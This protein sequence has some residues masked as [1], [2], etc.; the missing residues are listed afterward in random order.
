MFTAFEDTGATIGAMQFGGVVANVN[1]SVDLGFRTNVLEAPF[2]RPAVSP[3]TDE[4][5]IRLLDATRD[6]PIEAAGHDRYVV[7]VAFAS[8]TMKVEI[9][10]KCE[11]LS[12][13]PGHAIGAH[14]ASFQMLKA[15]G[16][17]FLFIEAGQSV[18]KDLARTI[19]GRPTELGDRKE[20][21]HNACHHTGSAYLVRRLL[22]SPSA[23]CSQS[24]YAASVLVLSEFFQGARQKKKQSA[25]LPPEVVAKLDRAIDA[26]IDDQ[27]TIED[28]ATYCDLP[29]SKFAKLFK[30]AT[31]YP[32]YQYVLHK[33]IDTARRWLK[34]TSLPIAEIAY[35]CGF[36][37]QAHMTS[38]FSRALGATPLQCRSQA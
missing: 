21:L 27:I 26:S 16:G 34:E 28:L 20:L 38:T 5:A 14:G 23:N 17:E 12:L 9:A 7:V 8:I 2:V 25:A 29:V 1:G 37:S 18:A 6:T 32:P 35:A 24:I 30:A 19:T 11:E 31:G 3:I 10:G 15:Q 13:S 33:R 36:S 4:V 22:N